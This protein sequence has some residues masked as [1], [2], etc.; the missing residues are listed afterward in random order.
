MDYYETDQG[1][2]EGELVLVWSGQ[3]FEN[4][5]NIRKY[6]KFDVLHYA[7]GMAWNNACRISDLVELESGEVSPD[8]EKVKNAYYG[9]VWVRAYATGGDEKVADDALSK[10]K[11]RE[12]KGDF[13]K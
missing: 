12:A 13:S 6:Q 7:G 4:S 1:I 11:V 9:D 8:P 3:L 10:Y 5:L 2:K